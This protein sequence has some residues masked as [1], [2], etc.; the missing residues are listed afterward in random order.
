MNSAQKAP[1]TDQA[2]ERLGQSLDPRAIR[3]RRALRQGFL[4][5]LEILPFNQ[6]TPQQIAE[7]AGVVRASFYLH[8]ASKQTMLDEIAK[9]ALTELYNMGSR[10]LD[11]GGSKAAALANCRHIENNKSLWSAL[12]NGG[13][14]GIVRE[15][16]LNLARKDSDERSMVGDRLPIELGYTFSSTVMMEIIAWWLRQEEYYSAEFVAELMVGLVFDPI[17]AVS[18]SPNLKF[19]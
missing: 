6:I 10:A 13:A 2:G 12:L 14:Q 4:D 7:K 9:D 17:R 16:L 18:T 19:S 15:E 3:T 5:L 11:E 1:G 8:Y